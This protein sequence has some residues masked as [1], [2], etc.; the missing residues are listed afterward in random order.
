MTLVQ[1][2]L[3]PLSGNKWLIFVITGLMLAACSPRIRPV[4]TPVAKNVDTVAKQKNAEVKVLPPPQPPV[5]VI[6]LILPFQLDAIDLSRG[7]PKSGLA[8]ADV[9]IEFY[10]GFKLALDS[11]TAR[12]YNFRLMV[13]DSKDEQTQTRSLAL[14]NKVRASDLIVGPVYPEGVKSFT[15]SFGGLKKTMVSPLSPTPPEDYHY[16]GLVTM[17]P[18]LEYHT[19]KVAGYISTK[20]KAKKVFI[21]KSGYSGD[22]KYTLPFKKYI[23]SLGKKRIKI[24][25]LT[26]VRGDLTTLIPQLSLTEQN[27][28]VIPATDQQFVQVTLRS[29]DLLLKQHYPITLFVHPGWEKATFLKPEQLERLNTFVTSS[30]RVNYHA[31][32][33][34]KFI[35]DFRRAYHA[36]PGEYAI[37][38]FDEGMYWGQMVST[39]G[40]TVAD[41]PDFDGLHNKF[42]F[43]NLPGTGYVN[44]NV[45]LYK[46]TNFDLKLVE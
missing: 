22:N 31:A 26:V 24:V 10:Q 8:K 19:H 32:S 17:I 36:E 34:V 1:N 18:P 20:L 9:A 38:G 3:P 40:R 14:L 7:A 37:K 43:V 12:N 6:S 41:F 4:V 28:F 5:A 39:P 30:D 25:E 46:Y 33:V 35:K 2:R 21:L 16:P 42:H 13:Y 44:T 23:D 27:I 45:R 29:L 15:Y 11:L